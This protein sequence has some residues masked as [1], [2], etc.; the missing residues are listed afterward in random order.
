MMNSNK[1]EREECPDGQYLSLLRLWILR[2]MVRCNGTGKFLRENRFSDNEVAELLG[3]SSEEIEDYSVAWAT[4]EL[5]KRLQALEAEAPTFP[6]G[7][8]LARNIKRLAER[9]ALS[10]VESDIL[11]FVVLQRLQPQFSEALEM[12]GDLVRAS[13]IRLLSVCLGHSDRAIQTALDDRGRLCRSALLTVDESRRYNFESKMDLLEGL[14]GALTIEQDDLFDLFGASLAPTVGTDLTLSDFPHLAQDISILRP[15][16]DAAVRSARRGVNV[17]IHGVPGTGKTEFVKALAAEIGA[18]L[19]SVPFETPSGHP[20]AGRDRF[21]SFRFAQSLLEGCR[22]HLMLFDEVEDVFYSSRSESRLRGNSSGIKGWV[23]NLLET[24]AVPVIWVTNCLD[25]IDGAYRRRFDYVLKMEPPPS[26]VRRRVLGKALG[27]L[28]VSEGWRDSAATHATMTAASLRRAAKVVSQAVDGDPALNIEAALSRVLTGTLDAL[29]IEPLKCAPLT[30]L[31]DYRLDWLNADADLPDL[32]EGLVRLGSGRVCLWGPPGTGKSEFARYVARRLDRPCL[33]QRASDILS[34]YVGVAERNISRM[35]DR[36]TADGA[37]LV[38]DEADSFL[39]TRKG[40]KH[41]WEVTQVNEM[42][43]AMESFEGVFVASTN[44][45][46]SFDE[47]AMRRFDVRVKLNFL[48]EHQVRDLF[49]MTADVLSL[50]A[51]ESDIG[52]AGRLSALTPGD[53]A[54]VARGARLCR[55]RTTAEFIERL[56]HMSEAKGENARRTIGFIH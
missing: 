55:P 34:P 5:S 15:Y 33:I 23:N 29:E 52:K 35:F 26:S 36:A 7:P 16:L 11:H 9:L 21:E 51:S 48:L 20:R 39:R 31:T 53:F 27:E 49:R 17:L 8:T 1:P 6:E 56:A 54:S 13:L 25:D 22:E 30:G 3:F 40:A 46:D 12:V 4:R 50:Q 28:S 37:V 42:L 41:S 47:A 18:R 10:E 45:L 44:L 2:L 19:M 14:A 32:A 24:N 43:T 38:L